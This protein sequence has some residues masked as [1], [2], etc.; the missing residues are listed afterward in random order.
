M[1]YTFGDHYTL[2]PACYELRQHGRLVRLEPRVFDCLAYLVQSPDR[3]VTKEEL[4][5]HLWPQQFVA[6]DSLTYCVAQ[7]RKALGDT[8]QTQQYIQTVRRRGY[9]FLAPV[10]VRPPAALAAASP[11]PD[12]PRPA[13]ERGQDPAAAVSPPAAGPSTP[14]AERRQLTILFCDLVD[15][16]VLASQLDPEDYR[17]VVRPYHAA[18]AE[19]IERFDGH[20]A[21]YLG[22]GLLVYFGY[23]Q[24]HEDDA[25]RAVRTGLGIV[26]ALGTLNARLEHDKG[27]RLAVRVGIHTGLAVVGAMGGGEKQEQL[28]LGETPNIAARLQGLAAPDTVVISATTAR[29]VAGYFVCQALGAQELKGVSQPLQV[30]R[31]LQASGAQT[32]LDVVPPRG[33]TPLVGRDE[34]VALLHRR[35]EQATTGL[36]QVV[37]LSGEP[38]IGKSRLVQVLTDAVAAEAHTRMEWRGSPYFQQSALSPVIDYLHRWLRWHPDDPPSERLRTLE[39]MLTASGV[40]L[41]EA[42]PLLA[43]L[44]SLPLPASYPPLTL[45]PR[46]QRQHTFDTLL[47]WLHA[48]AQRQ[49][50]LLVVEDLHWLDPSTVELLSL[51]IDQGAQARLCLILTARSEF[52]PAWAM[53]PHLTTLTLRRLAPDHVARVATHVAGDKTLP[54]AVLQEVVRKT[55]GVPLFVEELTKTVLESGLLQEHEARYELPGP[56]P[57]LAIPATL[58][59]ALMARLDRLGTAK[60]VA[61]LGATMGRTFAYDLLQTVA[62]LEATTLQAALA[63]LVEAEVVVQRGLPPQATYTFKHALIQDAAYQSLLRSTRQQHHQRIAQVL[64]AQFPETADEQPELLAH[65]ALRGEVWDKAVTYTRQASAK[66]FVRC[67]YREAVQCLERALKALSHLPI[68][69]TTMEHAVDLCCDLH[70]ALGPPLAHW[71]QAL[72]HLH[73]AE[74]IAVELGDQRRLG[75]VYRGIANVLRQLHE[76]EPALVYCQRAHAIATALG[77]VALQL[78]VNFDMGLIYHDLGRY[79]Q[80]I[81]C[82]Q[83]MLTALHRMPPHQSV[84]ILARPAIQAWVWMGQ[85]LGELGEFA[86]G[87]AYGDEA[88]QMAEA[89]DHLYERLVVALR[90]GALQVRQGTLHQAIPLLERAVALS[91]EAAMPLFYRLAG[92]QLALAYALAGRAPD[93]LS[94]LGQVGGKTDFSPTALAEAYLRAGGVEEAHRLAQRGLRDARERKARGFEVRALWLLGEIAMCHDPP[95]RAPAEAHY[96]QALTLA[97]ALGMRPLV[98]HCQ[99]GLGMLYATTGQ[100]EQARTALSTAIALYRG[101]D[102]TFWL[103][104]AEAA[105][106]QVEGR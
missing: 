67:A 61:Q 38:G 6:D 68:E 59:D 9:R 26:E 11:P 54:P 36:G 27:I 12:T 2:D 18:C 89:G 80:A 75:R 66:A 86:R 44:L 103:P 10:T 47:A 83:Q 87:L 52:H 20:I 74:P 94:V 57:P 85:Y 40:V 77:D 63:Q 102:M 88:R 72:T 60:I 84:G 1:L 50:V 49:P 93:A 17:E 82:V 78:W 19:V 33:L 29:L 73:A 34:E 4:V 81:G 53:V 71:E 92:T 15:S 76:Y 64:E 65:H 28:A 70:A 104:Q 106:A 24:A 55:D 41:S 62:P 23:P 45:T 16:T 14:D 46:Q 79:R 39:A 8:G 56:L 99:R 97:E 35:W 7:A 5:E 32:R 3:T 90:V 25:Q 69:R 95:D 58:H 51:L 91:Q 22:D 21:Q 31:A 48:E 96:H 105:L 30:S 98:A 101:M 13:E 42:V 100:Q 37:L 43:A